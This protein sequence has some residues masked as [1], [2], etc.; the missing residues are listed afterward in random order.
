M[1]SFMAKVHLLTT[2]NLKRPVYFKIAKVVVQ[3]LVLEP[4]NPMNVI[5]V[6]AALQSAAM[7][8]ITA[9]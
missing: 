2:Q 3:D 9:Y 7:S 4:G 1:A 5:M 6:Q 8:K